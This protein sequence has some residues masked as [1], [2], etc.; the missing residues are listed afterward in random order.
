MMFHR[1][2]N[3]TKG[4][5]LKCALLFQKINNVTHIYFTVINDLT[6]DQR[7]QR[8]CRTLAANGFEVTLVGKKSGSSVPLGKEIYH[9]HRLPCFFT[10]G[11][12]YY[13]EFNLRL[14][15]FLLFRK[16]DA[17]CAIDLDTI[18]PC[19]L[20][21]RLKKI[22]RI[23]DA[24][25]LFSEMK[26][27]VTRPGVHRFWQGIEKKY[28]PLFPNGYTVSQSIAKEFY[29][30]YGVQYQVIRNMPV[31]SP[32]TAID[33]FGFEE[34]RLI[35]QG[36]VNEARGFE[37]LVPAVM[38]IPS[39][40]YVYGEGNYLAGVEQLIEKH[41]AGDK[42]FLFGKLSPDI[43][44]AMTPN[45]YI[46]INLVEPRGLN[47]YY[48]LANKF[49]DYMHAGLPQITMKFPEYQHIN[50][51]YEIAVLIE[52]PDTESI[53]AAYRQL[54]DPEF[55]ER[56]RKNCFRAMEVYNWENEEKKLIEFYRKIME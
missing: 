1:P 44:R 21:A 29:K 43:L 28:I 4:E 52:T 38:Q 25:E 10:K 11:K 40:L 18:I 45:H 19:F 35:Y 41:K 42:I 50:D 54:C 34:K 37:Y 16:M 17:I 55:Y 13:L 47:Q 24:H 6:Y 8:I 31:Y 36:A 30:R 12:I 56:L 32:C 2:G 5:K 27:V 48:S 46:G 3:Y 7:M 15:L 14:L 22:K 20:I 23:Y 51:Q 9:Q 53:V 26:E 33:T 49:F 39:R